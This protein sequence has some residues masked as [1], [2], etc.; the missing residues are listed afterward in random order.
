MNTTKRKRFAAG[1]FASA[2]L[3]ILS[4][5]SAF[6]APSA[7]TNRIQVKIDDMVGQA[8]FRSESVREDL[9]R[10]AFYDAAS[11]EKWLGK[12]EFSYNGIG[13]AAA[14]GSLEFR[15]IDWRRSVGNLYQFSVAASYR[16]ADGE[17]VRLGTYHGYESGI[18]VSMLGDVGRA[19][20][21]AAEDAFRQAL[22]KLAELQA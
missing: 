5:T 21:D 8:D 1:I 15:V 7:E 2:A 10:T 12:Y 19:Y 13:E 22:K 17:L 20:A 11:R 3:L 6:G 9:L 18:A 14:P 4:A 16:N